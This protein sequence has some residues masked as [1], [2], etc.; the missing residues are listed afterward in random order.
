[1]VVPAYNSAGLLRHALAHLSAQTLAATAYEV[2]VVDDGSTDDTPAVIAA[3]GGRGQVRGLRMSTNRGRGPARNAGIRAA[4][5]PLVVF[6]DSDVLAPPDFLVRHLAMHTAPRGPAVGRGPVVTIPAPAV[7]ARPPAIRHS[8]AY[9]TTANASVPRQ[10]LLDAGLFDEAFPAY[11]GEDVDLGLRLKAR[12]LPRRYDHRAVAFHVEPP[13]A[14]DAFAAYLAKEEHRARAA[15]YLA[16]K[17]PGFAARVL[18]QDTPLHRTLH[19]LLAGGGLLDG[20]RAPVLARWLARRGY[21]GL[22]LLVARGA[23]NQH[24]MQALVRLRTR[25]DPRDRG[26]R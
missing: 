23:L 9:L 10:A 12:G 4:A 3:A 7:P 26:P 5:A 25:S 16:D 24:Y 14:F 18:I 1:V 22:S 2:V 19:F 21:R 15:C 13:L 6:I 17:H 20:R 8:P 11:G